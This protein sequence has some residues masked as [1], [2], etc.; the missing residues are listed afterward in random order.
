VIA[1]TLQRISQAPGLELDLIVTGMHLSDRFGRT[2]AEVE[3]SRIPIVTRIEVPI[4]EDSGRGMALS[5]AAVVSGVAEHLSANPRDALLVLGDR[6]EMLAAAT[7]ALFVG[8]PIVHLCGGE[9]SGSIDDSIRHSISK[10][11]HVHLVAAEDG[12]QRLLRMGEE[13]WRVHR[14]GAPGLVG[15]RALAKV[16]IEALAERYGFDAASPYALLLFHPVVQDAE[17]G[18]EQV[19]LLLERLTRRELQV[20]CLLPNADHG[21]T[22]IRD[23]IGLWSGHNLVSVVDH[24]PREDYV[25]AMAAAAILIGNSSSGIVEAASVGTAVVNCGDRQKDRL[26]NPNVFDTKIEHAPLDDAIERALAFDTSSLVN[27]YGD[28]QTDRRV[29]EIL[30]RIDFRDTR[31]LKKSMTY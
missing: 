10:L 2:E 17:M 9:R 14:I 15:L 19:A 31:L 16:P 21:N 18:G 13:P 23:Q 29:S 12:E 11:A 3:A 5:A 6:G 30:S 22:A 4:D 8:T 7:A 24:M 26:R 27:V 28:G 20:I 25:S 1:P